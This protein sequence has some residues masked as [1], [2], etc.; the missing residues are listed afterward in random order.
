MGELNTSQ[1]SS[2]DKADLRYWSPLRGFLASLL[3]S[4]LVLAGLSVLLMQLVPTLGFYGS[5]H[6]FPEIRDWNSVKITLQR[7]LCFGTCPAYSIEIRGNGSV[8]YQGKDCVAVKG[9]RVGH[10]SNEQLRALVR[11]FDAANYFS[12]RAIY[13]AN[14]TDGPVYRTSFSVDGKSKGVFDYLGMDADM[15]AD[16]NELEKM[17]DRVTGSERWTYGG[18]RTCFGYPVDDSWRHRARP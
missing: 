17:I 15:P 3:I 16:V 4:V 14:A 12:L 8:L 10:I 18:S 1:S 11:A 13:Q 5:P 2:R 7:G 6:S 9:A